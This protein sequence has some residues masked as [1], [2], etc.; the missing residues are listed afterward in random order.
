MFARRPER[1]ALLDNAQPPADPPTPPRQLQ[2]FHSISI[3][4]LDASD[5]SPQCY[6]A[7]LVLA[8]F[9]LGV[10]YYSYLAAPEKFTLIDALYFTVVTITT[11]GYGDVNGDY[12][13]VDTSQDKLFT[14]LFVLLGVGII[15]AAVGVVLSA[16]LDREDELAERLSRQQTTETVR[17]RPSLLGKK[18]LSPAQAKCVVSAAQ[19]VLVLLGG[20]LIFE[21]LEHVSLLTAFYWCCVSVT[22]VGY[23][24]VAP[25]T[26]AGKAFACVF[27]LVGTVLMAKS[28]GDIAGL[29]LEA[30]RKR[31]EKKVLEQYGDHLDGEE[32]AEILRYAHSQGLCDSAVRTGVRSPGQRPL[33]ALGCGRRPGGG[34]RRRVT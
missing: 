6:A 5:R 23:G 25:E 12:K 3:S 8:Y 7:L 10:L 9:V 34:R 30:R 31:L 17:R 11:V 2:H 24:D 29:P 21:R 22:T 19:L 15:G 4:D 27:L 18:A 14:A 1:N 32:F 20:T 33:G 26:F 13:L 28:L 16:I